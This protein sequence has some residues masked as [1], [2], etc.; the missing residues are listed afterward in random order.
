MANL[1]G[2]RATNKRS[3]IAG[4]RT[5]GIGSTIS[6]VL[7]RVIWI[8]AAIFWSKNEQSKRV[9]PERVTQGWVKRKKGG[10]SKRL[11]NQRAILTQNGNHQFCVKIRKVEKH[12]QTY[13]NKTR[14][15]QRG[16]LYLILLTKRS[17]DI[18][19]YSFLHPRKDV[20]CILVFLVE[21]IVLLKK[22]SSQ[23]LG[24]SLLQCKC[25]LSQRC[26]IH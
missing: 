3:S 26:T 25:L 14:F 5:G 17:F 21:S 9:V 23:H 6:C 24:R 20:S 2:E 7:V 11:D 18:S 8:G 10:K 22:Y 16:S 4:A 19:L 15:G 13:Q 12:N 1:R